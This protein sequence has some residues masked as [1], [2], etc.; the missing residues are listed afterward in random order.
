MRI[1]SEYFSDHL[2]EL[3]NRVLISVI[4]I[5][6]FSGLSY[7]FS[8]EITRF[9]MGPLFQARPDIVKLVYT[10]LTEAFVSYI[11]VAIIAGIIFSFPI[12]CYEAWM[13]VAPG[14]HDNEKKIAFKV[15]SWATLLFV[16]GILFSYFVV[17]PQA[18]AFLMDTRG[19]DIQALPKLDAYLTFV[20]RSSLA[21][22]LAF[23]IP[24]LMVVAGKTGLV[25]K[26]GFTR[27]RWYY[28]A[29]ILVLAFLLTAGDVFSAVL[30]AFPLFG[31][32][33]AGVVATR[34]F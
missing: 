4:T 17:M 22:G 25:D 34:L 13:Y 12:L 1:L 2:L 15:V 28:Y 33:E 7:L 27:K 6:V 14:L 23:E 24:F 26:A 8:T 21:F 9:L 18:L 5:A 11:K 32:Y 30:L 3:R 29:A 16:S 10:N 31:L 19:Y 20:A